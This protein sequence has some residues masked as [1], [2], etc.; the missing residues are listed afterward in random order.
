M[1]IYSFGM[2]MWEL[3]T[4]RK[5]F[6]D[7]NNDT[8]LIIKIC[9]GL[10]PPVVTNAP[11]GY[12]NLMKEC[13]SPNPN[14]RPTAANIDHRLNGIRMVETKNPTEIMRSSDHGHIMTN[15][16]YTSDAISTISSN[17]SEQ[18]NQHTLYN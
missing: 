14:K 8:E 7:Q 18:G 12:A 2:I 6:W 4:G 9:D 13:W 10:R 1:N 5:P 15:D 17:S 16:S 3:M 11:K